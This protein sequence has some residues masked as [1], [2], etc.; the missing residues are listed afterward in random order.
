MERFN[1]K[2]ILL[3]LLSLVWGSSF[4]LIKK[5]LIGLTPLQL[6]SLR[7][8]FAGIF[9][10]LIGYKKLKT[11][12]KKEWKWIAFSAIIGTFIPAF[13]FAFAETEIDSAIASILNSTTPLVT[14]ILGALFFAIGYSKNQLLGVLI[15]LSGSLLLIWSGAQVNPDQNYWF[16]GLVLAASFC[17]AINVNII[18]RYLQEVSALAITVGQ[19]AV[20]IFPALIILMFSGFFSQETF[21]SNELLPS[22]GYLLILAVVGTGVAK[23]IFNTLVKISTPVFASSVT[24]LIPIVALGWGLLDGERFTMMQIFA[25]VLIVVGVLFVNFRRKKAT[26][27]K[28]EM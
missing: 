27:K 28:L 26:A 13:L 4:I 19:F 15:G 21:E 18:K 12:Q 6:G 9:L 25:S 1:N 2:W 16:S 8:V 24:Y 10:M 5:S 11:I 22:I 3:L 20:I 17:Y 23:T 14:L 7:V